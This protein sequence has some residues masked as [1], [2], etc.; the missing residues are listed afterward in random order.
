MNTELNAELNTL[1]PRTDALAALTSERDQLRADFATLTMQAA[2]AAD[3]NVSLRLEVD[4]LRAEVERLSFRSS[5]LEKPWRFLARVERAEAELA[6]ERARLDWLDENAG[7]IHKI[8]SNRY[9]IFA[10]QDL[11][12]AIDAAMKEGAK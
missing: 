1:T 7:D 2:A 6:I 8:N 3:R 11:R 12:A 10:N 4:S 9:I 5:A